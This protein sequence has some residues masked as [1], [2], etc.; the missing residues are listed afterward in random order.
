MGGEHRLSVQT[1]M[2]TFSRRTQKWVQHTKGDFTAADQD[3]YAALLTK[4]QLHHQ[5][6]PRLED[7]HIYTHWRKLGADVDRL[8]KFA[9][10]L[11][12]RIGDRVT[13]YFDSQKGD[14]SMDEDTPETYVEWK[15]MQEERF[16]E[17]RRTWMDAPSYEYTGREMEYREREDDEFFR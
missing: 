9:H 4:H 2:H 17:S 10:E 8:V 14:T 16:L 13:W 7:L 15:V 11:Y 1:G 3:F 5:L 6:Q 12:G